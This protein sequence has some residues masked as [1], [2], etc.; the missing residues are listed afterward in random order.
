[1]NDEQLAQVSS[2]ATEEANRLG[3]PEGDGILAGVMLIF[4]HGATH[5]PLY[6][7]ISGVLR[8]PS[9]QGRLQKLYTRLRVFA[10]NV[11]KRLA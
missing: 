1:M 4:G 6:P 10:E 2:K 9:S 7:W 3:L 8:D 5:D 11:R